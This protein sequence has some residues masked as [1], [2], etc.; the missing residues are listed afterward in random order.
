M[1]AV[2]TAVGGGSSLP[3]ASR[4]SFEDVRGAILDLLVLSLAAILR[5]WNGGER[6]D[7][8]VCSAA[9][10]CSGPMA[11]AG[12]VTRGGTVAGSGG[13]GAVCWGVSRG[14]STVCQLPSARKPACSGHTSWRPRGS[15]AR[16]GSATAVESRLVPAPRRFPTSAIALEAAGQSSSRLQPWDANS[17]SLAGL[18]TCPGSCRRCAPPTRNHKNAGPGVLEVQATRIH[19]LRVPTDGGGSGVLCHWPSNTLDLTHPLIL[20][21]DWAGFNNRL[22]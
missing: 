4:C 19:Q 18:S 11:S 2:A 5:Q 20:W 7:L 15:T 13:P 16:G 22:G 3:L 10:W 6:S 8:C 9:P 17:V 14:D 12:T 1:G 21:T